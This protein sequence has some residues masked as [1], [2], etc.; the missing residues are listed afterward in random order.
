M[1]RTTSPASVN[2]LVS[3]DGWLL[4]QYSPALATPL[5][6]PGV[7]RATGGA[8]ARTTTGRSMAVGAVAGIGQERLA[9]R[10]T[11]ALGRERDTLS[12]F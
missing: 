5:G 6:I 1:V 12:G 2:W 9:T 3:C 4:D 8:D 10:G 11:G 7:P